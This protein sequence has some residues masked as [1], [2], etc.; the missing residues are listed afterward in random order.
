MAG[1]R[2]DSTIDVLLLD[3][4]VEK[5]SQYCEYNPETNLMEAIDILRNASVRN[6]MQA[7][8]H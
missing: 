8:T 4:N 6:P 5:V 1:K 2:N 3:R 7:G